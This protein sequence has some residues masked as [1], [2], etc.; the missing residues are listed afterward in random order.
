[1]KDALL[2]VERHPLGGRKKA[3]REM[4]STPPRIP[5]FGAVFTAY[6]KDKIK[7]LKEKRQDAEKEA[8]KKNQTAPYPSNDELRAEAEEAKPE[9]YF[10]VY[11]DSG[12]AIRRV[13]GS[14]DERIPAG[15]VGF[16]LSRGYFARAHWRGRRIPAGQRA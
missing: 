8:A 14:T 3:F 9:L 16:A 10:V 4:H 6:L 12:A 13:D 5:A 1:M 7:T 15:S 2:Y 11:D